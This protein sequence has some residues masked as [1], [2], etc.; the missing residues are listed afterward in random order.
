MSGGAKGKHEAK[1][2]HEA[3]GKRKPQPKK[4]GRHVERGFQAY[5]EAW[6]ACQV[7]RSERGKKP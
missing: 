4:A 1:G 6:R 2:T 5:A 3:K 7:A